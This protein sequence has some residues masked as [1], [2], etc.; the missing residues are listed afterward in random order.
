MKF[1]INTRFKSLFAGLLAV[2]LF[3]AAPALASVQDTTAAAAPVEQTAVAT[4]S[5]VVATDSTATATTT[6]T[7]AAAAPS[8]S[9]TPTATTTPEEVKVID[10]QVYKNLTY[11][12]LFFLVICAVFAVIGKVHSI[13]TLTKR[14]N[15]TYNPLANNTIQAVLFLVFLVAFLGFVYYGYAVWGD[16]SWRPAVTEH[17]KDVDTMFIITTVI[18]TVVLVLVHIL[19]LGFAFLYRMRAKRKAYFYP[20]NDAI[21]RLWTIV[22]AVVLTVLVLFGFFTWRKITNIPEELKKSALQVEVLGEQ[23]QWTIR[24][25]GT[26]GVIG[27]R[28]FKMTTP[29]NGYGIDF[30]DKSSWDDIKGDEIVIPVN[31]PVRFH[32]LSKDIIH[33]FYIPDFRVQI[34]AV[35]GMTNY[36]QFTPTVTTEEMRDKM[37]D[38]QY[39]Y[40]MLCAK[41]CGASHYNMQKNVR[42]VT[43]AEYSEWLSKQ[44]KFFTED[45]QKE[46][47]ELH[48]DDTKETRIA[49][50]IN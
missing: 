27:K 30:N 44:A 21:E 18:I 19:L 45:V 38:P 42:V 37:N 2:N 33:S 48:G 35:P 12:I 49:A 29:L 32:I 5:A 26:D 14:V 28:N 3:F 6:D 24:Y 23:F 17:G 4:D 9:V 7:V 50:S 31:R 41:I 36:F 10:P 13:Y 40:V 1:K 16:W 11:Y 39:N 15:G 47:A 34:N 25:P 43:E 20:H 46:F 22:P 8:N